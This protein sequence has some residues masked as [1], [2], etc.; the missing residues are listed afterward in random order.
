MRDAENIRQDEFDSANNQ[1]NQGYDS[2]GIP[3]VKLSEPQE[4]RG[5]QMAQEIVQGSRRGVDGGRPLDDRGNLQYGVDSDQTGAQFVRP[6]GE[7]GNRHQNADQNRR[8]RGLVQDQRP[9]SHSGNRQ[10]QDTS[11][12]GYGRLQGQQRRGGNRQAPYDSMGY[13]NQGGHYVGSHAPDLDMKLEDVLRR[14]VHRNPNPTFYPRP[15]VSNHLMARMTNA[16]PAQN[17]NYG[18][19]GYSQGPSDAFGQAMSQ[20]TSNPTSAR[21]GIGGDQNIFNR[22]LFEQLQMALTIQMGL[23]GPQQVQEHALHNVCTSRSARGDIKQVL[24]SRAGIYG[25]EL[26]PK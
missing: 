2:R 16:Q 22:E 9:Q 19:Y 6:Q 25:E 23:N 20:I 7:R 1:I 10:Q 18:G 26:D 3:E 8:N 5:G 14:G 12:A 17:H 13:N 21:Q 11:V 4:R 15:Q 24:Q